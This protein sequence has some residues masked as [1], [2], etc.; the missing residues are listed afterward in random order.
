[1]PHGSFELNSM[2]SALFDARG[3]DR[4]KCAAK[5]PQPVLAFFQGVSIIGICCCCGHPWCST[6]WRRYRVK[7]AA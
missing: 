3:G 1:M 2:A 4:R 6:S 5:R 7:G